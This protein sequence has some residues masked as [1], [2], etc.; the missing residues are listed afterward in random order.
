MKLKNILYALSLVT[1]SACGDFL[2][3]KSQSEYVPKN[4]NSLQEMLVGAAYP[5]HTTITSYFIFY[6]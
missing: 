2:E 1:L 5:Q 3:P 4:S 6:L